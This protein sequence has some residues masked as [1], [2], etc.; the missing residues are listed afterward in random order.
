[1]TA[2]TTK[3]RKATT[4]PR[5]ATSKA[6]PTEPT[7]TDILKLRR[8]DK[9][10][11]DRVPLFAM[12]DE[13][14]VEVIYTIPKTI[15][16]GTALKLMRILTREPEVVAVSIMLEEI[17]GTDGLSALEAAD[18]PDDDFNAIVDRIQAL[19]FGANEEGKAG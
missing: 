1:M 12:E 13:N 3:P 19:V 9:S 18:L 8:R 4:K 17:L 5:K 6:A 11:E 2:N 14:G 15:S 10:N 16:R 7:T